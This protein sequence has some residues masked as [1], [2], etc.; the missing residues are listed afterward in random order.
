MG[1]EDELAARAEARKS[2]RSLR[3]TRAHL[4]PLLHSPAILENAGY[5]VRVP[6]EPGGTLP[7]SEGQ[8]TKCERCGQV[9]VIKRKNESDTCIYHWG[10]PRTTRIN[11]IVYF[12]AHIVS[13]MR[14]SRR[15]DAHILLLFQVRF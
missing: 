11:G 9:F 6:D 5:M 8:T 7:S 15:K 12:L 4:D 14:F 2:L 10:R 3:L 13:L 1:T